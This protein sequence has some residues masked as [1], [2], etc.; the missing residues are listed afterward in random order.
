MHKGVSM[1]RHIGKGV[2]HQVGRTGDICGSYGYVQLLQVGQGS[3]EG[4]FVEL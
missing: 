1:L 4:E 2:S 3:G